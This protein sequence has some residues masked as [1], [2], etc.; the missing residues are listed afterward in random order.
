MCCVQRRQVSRS[1]GNQEDL[2]RPIVGTN[3]LN[4]KQCNKCC[5][6]V[7]GNVSKLLENNT[8]PSPR[9]LCLNKNCT[10]CTK[11]IQYG[12]YFLP[13][14]SCLFSYYTKFKNL[15]NMASLL[16]LYLASISMLALLVVRPA[17]SIQYDLHSMLYLLPRFLC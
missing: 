1:P 12:L 17:L 16:G 13:R 3:S 11:S 2:D 8:V 5:M 10:D 7:L 4:P 6:I 14:F 15:Y 9:F